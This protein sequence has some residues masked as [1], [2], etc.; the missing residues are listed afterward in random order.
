LAHLLL[1]DLD[2]LLESRGHRFCRYVGDGNIDVHSRAAGQRVMESATRF[3]E[4]KLQLKGFGAS[5]A[6]I[7]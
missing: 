5:C 6:A 1:D 7:A 2:Q 4:E 3:L